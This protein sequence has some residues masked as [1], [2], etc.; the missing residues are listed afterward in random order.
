[1]E[2]AVKVEIHRL[3]KWSK[4]TAGFTDDE[5]ADLS[6]YFQLMRYARGDRIFTQGTVG[7][8]MGIV[9]EGEAEVVRRKADGC[10][11][12]IAFVGPDETVGEMSI[13]EDQPRMA[14]VVAGTD[15]SILLISRTALEEM[16][17]DLPSVG[18][19]FIQAT[20]K[21]LAHRVRNAADHF[22]KIV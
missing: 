19:K 2:V 1:M 4:F 15:C 17:R 9:I 18:C 3:L 14:D 5:I 10:G 13:L 21:V 12:R 16:L 7:I 8:G 6:D 11:D 20:A 22:G